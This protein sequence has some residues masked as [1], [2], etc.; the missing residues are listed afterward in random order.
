MNKRI[1]IALAALCLLALGTFIMLRNQVGQYVDEPYTREEVLLDTLVTIKA[2]GANKQHVEKTVDQAMREIQAVDEMMNVYDPGSE[3]SRTNRKANRSAGKKVH[4]SAD[5][6][7]VIAISKEYY[8]NTGGAFDLSVAP[9]MKLW[10]FN[11]KPS[12]PRPQE[13]QKV[14]PLVNMK[15]VQVDRTDN[16]IRFKQ[17]GTAL[18]LG[19]VAK[20]YAVD[21][22]VSVLKSNDIKSALVTTGSTTTVIGQKPGDTPWTIGIKNPRKENATIGILKPANK[23]ISTSGDYQ[24]YFVKDGKRYHHILDPKTGQPSRKCM[25]VTVITSKSCTEADILSTAFFI[26]GYPKSLELLRKIDDTDAVIVDAQGKV[27][28]TPGLRYEIKELKP[29]IFDIR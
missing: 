9:V 14:L 20:G 2:Y 16:T 27:H 28:A 24:S 18:D 23:S 5:L 17:P 11:E 26:M 13:L 29:S 21:K 8:G 6:T 12:V 1:W 15:N 25:S 3:I 7:Q 10:G 19:G 4:I 22:A